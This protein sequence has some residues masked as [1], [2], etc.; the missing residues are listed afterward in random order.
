[1]WRK[2]LTV[3]AAVT[4]RSAWHGNLL[5]E[6]AEK[7]KG[8]RADEAWVEYMEKLHHRPDQPGPQEIMERLWEGDGAGEFCRR[9]KDGPHPRP[10]HDSLIYDARGHVVG[11]VGVS[12]DNTERK[13]AEEE[14]G[15]LLAHEWRARA[16]AEERKR[17]SRELHDRV[18]HSM[19]VVHQSLELYEVFKESKPSQAEAKMKLARETTREALDL[20]GTLQGA[21]N[22]EAGMAFPRPLEPPQDG[23]P[24]VSK[25]HF[26]RARVA[27]PTPVRAAI[28]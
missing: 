16:E 27:H 1:M 17:I 10:R 4:P 21:N 3:Q 9:R 19:G 12:T 8:G 18:A 15:R 22:M 14:R 7:L 28:F 20:P 6:Y 26:R 25:Q 13:E 23:V 24:R 11:V 5:E 2:L